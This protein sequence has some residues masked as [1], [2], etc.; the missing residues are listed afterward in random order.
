MS[1]KKIRRKFPIDGN[2]NNIRNTSDFWFKGE[3]C[4]TWPSNVKLWWVYIIWW[5]NTSKIGL[6]CNVE[7]TIKKCLWSTKLS[8]TSFRPIPI[9][10]RA[11]LKIKRH[12]Q[13][14]IALSIFSNPRSRGVSRFSKTSSP[15]KR[16]RKG[17]GCLPTSIAC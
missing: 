8:I 16:F 9:Y 11:I 2:Q 12:K 10:S 13:A 14:K 17:P 3:N 6:L 7:V 15:S 5:V 4:S 1:K